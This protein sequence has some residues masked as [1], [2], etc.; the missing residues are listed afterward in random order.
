[1]IVGHDTCDLIFT[2]RNS[3]GSPDL[4]HQIPITISDL[5]HGII[6]HPDPQIDLAIIPIGGVMQQLKEQGK[7]PYIV[8]CHDHTI[9]TAK[10]FAALTPLEDILTVGFPGSMWDTTHNLPIFHRG[11]T[12]TPAYI[13][14][15]GRTEFLIDAAVWPGASGSPVFLYEQGA[16]YDARAN[17]NTFGFR[18]NLLGIVFATVVQDVTGNIQVQEIPTSPHVNAAV[19]SNLGVCIRSS[20]LL[21]FQLLLVAHGAKVPK[22]YVMRT[23]HD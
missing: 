23:A 6:E 13:D 11:I 22:G 20:R 16:I 3:D 21:D 2:G 4:D 12:A 7:V 15:Q 8:N 9:P 10:E 14:F 18:L 1:V 17:A 19:P 5:T